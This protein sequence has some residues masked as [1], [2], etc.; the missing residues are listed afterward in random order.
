MVY[1]R[2]KMLSWVIG[3]I[4]S[5]G[6]LLP[7]GT[8]LAADMTTIS[9][10]VDI[11][12]T[13]NYPDGL[14]I[15]KDVS[16]T[17]P[18]GYELTLVDDGVEVDLEAG[19]Y[20]GDISVVVTETHMVDFMFASHA[21]RMGLYVNDGQIVEEKSVGEVLKGVTFDSESAEGGS[22]TVEGDCF[23]GIVTD[24]DTE[25]S[26]SNMS[27][28][29]SGNGGNDFAGYGAAIMSTGESILDVENVTIDTEGAISVGV[30]AGGD[31]TLYVKDATIITGN[32]KSLEGVSAPMMKEVPWLLGIYGNT[33][34][35]NVLAK[36]DVTYEDCY[37]EA[38]AWGALSTDS[39]EDASLT[40]INTT[41]VVTDSGYGSYADGGV[42]NTY[43]NCIF[44]VPDYGLIVAAGQCGALFDGGTV[45]DADRFGIM[46]HKNQDGTVTITDNTVI[47]AGETAFL[48]KSDT[49]NTAYPNLVVD[50]AQV[51]SGTGVILHL[52]ESDDPGIN[53]DGGGPGS[54]DMWSPS[55]T[56]P[57]VV[58]VEDDNDTAD[59]KADMTMDALFA[60][61]AL[62]G[63][64]YN[65]RWT[66][67]QNLS[68]SFENASIEGVISS[69][70]QSHK[71]VKPGELIT[72]DTREELGEVDAVA[73]PTVSNGMLVALDKDSKWTVTGTSYLS[74]LSIQNGAEITAPIGYEV[75]MTVDGVVTEVEKGTYVGDVVLTLQQS[76]GVE[77]Q[78]IDILKGK[79]DS[80][81]MWIKF[82][83]SNSDDPVGKM[84]QDLIKKLATE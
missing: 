52:M 57:E 9:E 1:Q 76:E 17:A 74:L 84:L 16:I 34:S 64:I 24:G 13:T 12:E 53:P 40:A 2:N 38:E 11:S 29:Y 28:D 69:A 45:V 60:N 56:V 23:N 65:S 48:V 47:N 7:G 80:P 41:I 32:A 37:V 42:F 66:A 59:T 21:F 27:F 55:Y 62:V 3:V 36:A 19:N 70:T 30:F 46:W 83:K 82:I 14:K 51:H 75:V 35:T 6:M 72:P 77:S 39:C 43:T 44:D 10:D 18:E 5:M 73:S 15:Q 8:V 81:G 26:I 50:N 79:T 58:P 4:L 61:T 71:N 54:D 67:G 33:R 78:V 68:V 22:V 31:S 20:K 25:Y 63:D 49:A